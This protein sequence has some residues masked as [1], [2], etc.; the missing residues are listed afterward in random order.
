MIHDTQLS[1][2]ERGPIPVSEMQGSGNEGEKR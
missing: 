1:W 2:D